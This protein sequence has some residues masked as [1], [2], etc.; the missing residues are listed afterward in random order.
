MILPVGGK[1]MRADPS[2]RNFAISCTTHVGRK[3]SDS[4]D[5]ELFDLLSPLLFLGHGTAGPV[6]APSNCPGPSRMKIPT[7]WLY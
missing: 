6:V 3:V 5:Q 2:V 7:G 4:A 1:K